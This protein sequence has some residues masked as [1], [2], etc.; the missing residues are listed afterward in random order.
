MTKE[1]AI[2]VLLKMRDEYTIVGTEDEATKY[3]CLSWA[4]QALE[5]QK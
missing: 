2:E 3:H 5:E 1:E 4:I